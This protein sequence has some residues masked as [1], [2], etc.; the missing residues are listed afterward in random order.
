MIIPRGVGASWPARSKMLAGYRIA[1]SPAFHD[2]FDK[3]YRIG[4]II[5]KHPVTSSEVGVLSSKEVLDPGET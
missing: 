2:I 5:R 3:I 1:G 4:S